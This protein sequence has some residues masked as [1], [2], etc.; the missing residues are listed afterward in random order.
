[1]LGGAGKELAM[2]SRS[3]V[4]MSGEAGVFRINLDE[5]GPSLELNDNEGYSTTLGSTDLVAL[6][7]G[8]KERTAAAS[9]VLFGKDKKVLWSAP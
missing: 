1:M 2:L 6:T 5:G 9:L 4:A 7:S 3:G 8:R